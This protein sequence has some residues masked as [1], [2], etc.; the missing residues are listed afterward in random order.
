MQKQKQKAII[1]TL[2]TVNLVSLFLESVIDEPFKI[3]DTEPSPPVKSN[4]NENDTDLPVTPYVTSHDSAEVINSW[5]SEDS[6]DNNITVYASTIM[7]EVTN[8]GSKTN[9]ITNNKDTKWW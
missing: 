5:S 6:L 9:I 7:E 3:P 1:K 4:I 8:E 2:S